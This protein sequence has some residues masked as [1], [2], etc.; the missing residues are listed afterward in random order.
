MAGVAATAR[1]IVSRADQSTAQPAR[2]LASP[3]VVA[4]LNAIAAMELVADKLPFIPNRTDPAPLIGRVV[5]GGLIGAAIA[6]VAGHDRAQGTLI[7]AV[8][9]F[10]GAHAGF[11]LRRALTAVLPAPVA[12][13]VEDAAVG[14]L[15]AAGIS[16]MS[17]EF[18]KRIQRS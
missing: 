3:H 17:A 13:L 4:T 10:A 1:G 14:A 12:G 5:A 15:A 11:Q 8:A 18:A 7:G 9:A 6:A 16:A 2:F